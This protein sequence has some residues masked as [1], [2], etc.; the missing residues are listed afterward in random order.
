MDGPIQVPQ[1]Y[2]SVLSG[3]GLHEGYKRHKIPALIQ[4]PLCEEQT[5]RVITHKTGS[6]LGWDRP[7]LPLHHPSFLLSLWSTICQV[8]RARCHTQS[9][10]S[11]GLHSITGSDNEHRNIGQEELS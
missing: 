8:Y 2:W 7:L 1:M 3:G 6:V 9:L 5:F 4:L 11:W 10:L